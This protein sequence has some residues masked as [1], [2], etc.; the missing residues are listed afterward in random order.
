MPKI[1]GWKRPGKI[2]RR[3]HFFDFAL[4]A[5]SVEHAA[6]NRGVTG[7]SPVWGAKEKALTQERGCFS[8]T[9][10]MTITYGT[11]TLLARYGC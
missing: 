9:L 10:K 8:F 3:R 11:V 7:S 5:Q 2:G 1:L 4:I 6:V